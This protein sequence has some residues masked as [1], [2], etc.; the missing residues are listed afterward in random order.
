MANE[1]SQNRLSV[2]LKNAF[3]LMFSPQM[4]RSSISFLI[5]MV[6]AVV[7][8]GMTALGL[9]VLVTPA[10]NL[11]FG[12][13]IPIDHTGIDQLK[14]H[15]LSGDAT[16]PTIILVSLLWPFSFLM[17]GYIKHKT[18]VSKLPNLVQNTFYLLLLW[19]WALCLWAFAIKIG[20][21]N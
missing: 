17:A 8:L 20:F 15:G 13:N 9:F 1:K 7:S 5:A 3:A 18:A 10:I 11:L 2:K 4:K 21:A 14:D 12:L 16:W 6:L 19:I